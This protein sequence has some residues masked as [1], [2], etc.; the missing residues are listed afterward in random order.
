MVNPEMRFQAVHILPLR[1]LNIVTYTSHER[2]MSHLTYN[3]EEAVF[4][5]FSFLRAFYK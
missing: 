3:T 5:N 2:V 4:K 1:T